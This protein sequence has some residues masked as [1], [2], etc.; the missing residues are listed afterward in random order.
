MSTF[1]LPV[2]YTVSWL[3]SDPCARFLFEARN[4]SVKDETELYNT[5]NLKLN[6]SFKSIQSK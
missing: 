5:V 6:D 4:P 2:R 3:D 1:H